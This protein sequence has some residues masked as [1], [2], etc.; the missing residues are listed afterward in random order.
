M[1]LGYNTNG[2][3]GYPLETMLECL[4]VHGYES[5]AITLDQQVLNPFSPSL[6]A[7]LNHISRRL[8]RYGMHSVIETG[9]RFL[10][11]A[12][13]KHQPTLVSTDPAERELRIL[14]LKRAIE[15]ASNLGSDCVSLWSGAV[16]SGNTRTSNDVWNVLCDGVDEICRFAERHSVRLGFE[17][18]PGMFIATVQDYFELRDRC[19]HAA[20]QLT[21]DLGHVVCQDEGPIEVIATQVQ[22]HLI[23]VHLEDVPAGVHLHLPLGEGIMDIRQCLFALSTIGYQGGVHL[24]LSRHSHAFPQLAADSIRLLREYLN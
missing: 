12:T 17:P 5:V 14:F 4:H 22:S 3:L 15:I 24:E 21:L 20:L 13:E 18:E 8:F 11:R 16:S 9:A 23:N 2:A 10:L 6:A 19:P 7:D 1:R